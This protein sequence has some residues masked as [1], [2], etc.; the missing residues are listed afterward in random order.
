MFSK[1]LRTVRGV[2]SSSERDDV[3]NFPPVGNVWDCVPDVCDRSAT[4]RRSFQHFGLG[5]VSD[6]S[7]IIFVTWKPGLTLFVG[8]RQL[9]ND[10]V[11]RAYYSLTRIFH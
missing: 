2:D 4:T 10:K 9:G 5:Q 7:R 3:I 8:I 6:Q 1:Y 11:P